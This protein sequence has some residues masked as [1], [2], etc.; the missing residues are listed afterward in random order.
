M[1]IKDVVKAL[2]TKDQN[3]DVEF[4]VVAKDDGDLIAMYATSDK[5]HEM[6]EL[7]SLFGK[8]K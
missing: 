3:R 6:A 1:L 8:G 4:I 7:L 2:K 5:A